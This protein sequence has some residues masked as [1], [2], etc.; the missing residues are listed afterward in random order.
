MSKEILFKKDE[1]LLSTTDLDSNIKYAN[2]K[3]CDI[4]GYSSTELL[5]NPHNMVRHPDMPKAAFEDLWKFTQSGHSWMGP[6]KNSCKNGDYYWVNAFVTP[7]KDNHGKVFEYQSVRTLPDRD[8][9]D[10]AERVY[11]EIKEGKPPLQL[12]FSIDLTFWFQLFFICSFVFSVL[13]ATFS[14]IN[15]IL[16][17]PMV[18]ISALFTALFFN[19]RLKFKKLIKEAK[20]VF[21]NPLMSFIYSGNNNAISAITLALKMRE[22]ELKAVVGRVCD[23]SDK[24]TETAKKSSEC[25]ISVSTILAHQNN[26]TEQVATA[27]N[28]MSCTVQDLAQVIGKA[29]QASQQGLEISNQG[30]QIVQETIVANNDLA[31]QLSEVEQAISRLVNAS[32]SIETVLNEISS[33]AD[34]TN[35]LALN[36]AI[37]AARA[38]EQGRGFAV[39]ADEVRA[40]AMRTQQSTTEI[41]KLLAQLQ[42]ESNFANS[43]MEKGSELSHNCVLLSEKTGESLAKIISEVSELANLNTQIATAIEEQSLVSEEINRNIVAISDMATTTEVHGQQSVDLSSELLDK[44]EEQQALVTQFV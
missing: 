8:V 19:W 42:T 30:Q 28:E 37:E 16:S 17:L 21:D 40:L 9:V 36:A 33:I 5:G 14:D 15:L 7:I 25:G 22:A 23:V 3:F 12:R 20:S 29:A 13:V 38:G 27:M 31:G 6:V 32:K 11:K 18:V 10:R 34:Q 39:V 2:K 35:L 4:S 43:A 41:N 24:L 1:I 26:E 44:I